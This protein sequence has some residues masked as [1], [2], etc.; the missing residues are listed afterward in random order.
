MPRE[1]GH[2]HAWIEREPFDDIDEVD[3]DPRTNE[4]GY[5]PA[6]VGVF[7]QGIMESKA[8]TSDVAR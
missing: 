5:E 1:E 2:A 3:D 8:I 4:R 7:A 6:E